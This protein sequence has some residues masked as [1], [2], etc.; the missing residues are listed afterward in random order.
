MARQPGILT[1]IFA[2]CAAAGG[3]PQAGA[4]LV[5]LANGQLVEGII[6]HEME[7]QLRV[8]VAWQGY[9]TLKR[10]VVTHIERQ[11]AQEHD[12][13]L[14]RWREETQQ[15]KAKEE[16]QQ[17]FEAEQRV[18]HLVK[19]RGEWITTEEAALIRQEQEA[20]QCERDEQARRDRDELDRQFKRLEARIA[21][22]ES[23]NLEL[24]REVIRARH[25][26]VAIPQVMIIHRAHRRLG[27][28]TDEHG[29]ILRVR[30]HDGHDYFVD[31]AGEHVDLERH[32]DHLAFEDDAGEH[33]DL[34]RLP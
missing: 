31:P 8:Q 9:I 17:Q 19:Y 27:T 5:T 10:D 34:E 15:A 12:A 24:R 23:E 14:S 21:E 3:M 29:N 1:A 22:L 18:R 2:L 13:L 30:Q 32:G 20:R 33:H 7:D 4:D 25:E 28:F 11:T 26:L 6:I 16:A